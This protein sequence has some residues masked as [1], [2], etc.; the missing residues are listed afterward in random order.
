MRK[1]RALILDAFAPVYRV[2]YQSADDR[3]G[4][5]AYA[6]TGALKVDI[7]DPV[8]FQRIAFTR[9]GNKVYL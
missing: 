6:K 7:K 9:I 3:I 2:G 8:I 5:P 4:L 1:D